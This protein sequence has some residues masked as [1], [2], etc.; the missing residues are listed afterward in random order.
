[1]TTK[2]RKLG[3]VGSQQIADSQKYFNPEFWS[4]L[5]P[6]QREIELEKYRKIRHTVINLNSYYEG[7][8][9]EGNEGDE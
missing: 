3:S 4:K 7:N 9:Y 2:S 8:E 6:E 1:M 5:T